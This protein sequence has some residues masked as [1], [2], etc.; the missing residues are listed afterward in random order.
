MMTVS[1]LKLDT[2][3]GLSRGNTGNVLPFDPSLL[4]W[5]FVCDPCVCVCV[6]VYVT[7]VY[8]Y[9]YVPVP[10]LPRESVR[11]R[12]RVA[13][14]GADPTVPWRCKCNISIIRTQTGSRSQASHSHH[15]F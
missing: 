15:F 10:G 1:V 13:S 7:H 12:V 4:R 2:I 6:C 8:V 5:A 9:V 11:R 3:R 14:R